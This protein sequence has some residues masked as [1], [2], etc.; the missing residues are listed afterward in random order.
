MPVYSWLTLQQGIN[1]LR[2]RLQNTGFWGQ[3]ELQFY[4]INALRVW[5]AYTEIWQQDFVF[6][7]TAGTSWYNTSTLAGSPRLRT[8]TD[9]EII[10]FMQYLL[11]EP[12][13]GTGVWTGTNQFNLNSILY[14][15]QR[16]RDEVIQ[17]S[18]CNVTQLSPLAT[19]PGT[20]RTILADT[21][22]EPRR[23]RFL[24]NVLATTG[25]A[26]SGSTQLTIAST[27]G[28]FP[29]QYVSGTGIQSGSIVQ[30]LSGAVVT[31]TLPTVSSLSA[32]PV[33]F[34]QANTLTR[35]DTQAFQYF[36]P[37]YLQT[38]SVPESWSVASEPPLA[39]DVDNTP[40]IS[41]TY[42]MIAL[43]SGPQFAPLATSLMGIPDDWCWLPAIGA[44]ADLLNNEAERTDSSRAAYCLKRFTDGLKVMSQSNWLLQANINGVPVDTPAIFE[45]DSYSPEW[46][47]DMRGWPSLVQAGMDFVGTPPS[48]VGSINMTLVA[49]APIPI[50]LDDLVQ[51]SRDQ[52]DV[53]L[54]Y[55]QRTASFK[56]GGAEWEA[57]VPL[58][59]DFY[60]AAMQTNK[61]LATYGLF[62]DILHSEGRRQDEVQPR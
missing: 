60:R 34:A 58:E 3:E 15:L 8:T 40:S 28:V 61:R 53:V 52:W 26:S 24:G 57:T 10:S 1:A 56:M 55:A 19:T 22:L 25:T 39:F 42:D 46:Q 23:M 9:A 27:V 18:G 45:M 59:A 38:E 6:P 44:M 5:N 33:Q 49:N 36:E 13:T 47:N 31:L 50:G 30:S 16:R 4:I 48:E 37:D 17:A 51:V 12:P 41:G 35:E 32:T 20:R 21:V 14:A 29:G 54:G 11:L 43:E 2:G 7:T 62:T